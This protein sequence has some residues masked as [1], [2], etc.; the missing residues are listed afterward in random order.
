MVT[1]YEAKR[2]VSTLRGLQNA[3]QSVTKLQA[4]VQ[5]MDEEVSGVW[6]NIICVC[7]TKYRTAYHLADDGICKKC[8]HVFFEDRNEVIKK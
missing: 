6:L 8:N 5:F 1:E 3:A 7:G 4:G 2:V